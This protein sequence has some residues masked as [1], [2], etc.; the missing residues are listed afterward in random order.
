MTPMTASS[1]NY[2]IE[3]LS[4]GMTLVM[5]P[6]QANRVIGM[7]LSLPYPGATESYEDTGLNSFALRVLRRGT[8][9]RPCM[10]FDEALDDIG[11]ELTTAAGDLQ[12]AMTLKCTD[13]SLH[14]TLDLMQ[15]MILHPA[16]DPEDIERERRATMAALRQADDNTMG[17]TMRILTQ[18]MF[19]DSGF[20]RSRSGLLET[21]PN[22][23]RE[24][25]IQSAQTLLK[26]KNPVA[27]AVGNFRP[28]EL[29]NRLETM[30]G[31]TPFT[32]D[33]PP[34]CAPPLPPAETFTTLNRDCNQAVATVG[35]RACAR[36][37]PDFPAL[38]M[39]VAVLG[40][41][42]SSRFF[43][44]L[45]D[46]QGLAYAT[47]CRIS[48]DLYSG[49][50]IGF[51]ATKSE[52]REAAAQGMLRETEEIK[53]TLVPQVELDRARNFVIGSL[54][55]NAQSNLDR[56]SRIASYISLGLPPDGEKQ[57]L[58]QLK[59]VTPKDIREAARKY[60]NSPTRVELI[61]QTQG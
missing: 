8:L 29:K 53:N 19:P 50:V 55:I 28:E 4:N 57:Y 32:L 59:K 49:A 1:Q 60:L 40:E 31:E 3:Q 30:F 10:A 39:A 56:A 58:E 34:I 61:P 52:T 2:S 25:L 35:W 46:E 44:H 38:R 23:C 22:F 15:D 43:L 16:F 45:R 42:M 27:V 18:T 14:E 5:L 17:W 47:G 51:I 48:S 13:D 37:H 26:T 24:R 41:S 7:R 54:L 6:S 12:C 9:T 11:A 21:V 33:P 20:G 36:L